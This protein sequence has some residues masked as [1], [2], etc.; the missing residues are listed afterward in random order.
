MMTTETTTPALDAG[1]LIGAAALCLAALAAPAR[2]RDEAPAGREIYIQRCAECHGANGEGTELDYPKPL[3]GDRTLEQLTTVVDETMPSGFP[4]ECTGEDAA[5]VS[6][7][8][9]DA[10]YSPEAQQRNAPPPIELSRLTVPQYRNAVAD[11]IATFRGPMNRGDERGLHAEYFNSGR[12]DRRRRVLESVDPAVD[13]DFGIQAPPSEGF[14]NR[15][16]FSIRWEGAVLAPETGHY[17]IIVESDQA[18][19]LYLNDMDEPLVDA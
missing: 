14:E 18:T 17:D 7:Y 10:F 8:I 1:R 15:N 13:F 11:L 2:A 3:T 19:R 16:E 5:A 4:E 12:Y 6:A 9:Y